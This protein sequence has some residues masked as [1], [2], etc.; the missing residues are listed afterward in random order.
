MTSAAFLGSV[1][2]D[3]MPPDQDVK[4]RLRDLIGIFNRAAPRAPGSGVSFLVPFVMPESDVAVKAV[5]GPGGDP[6]PVVT[7]ML[8]GEA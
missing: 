3:P 7:I 8:L 2:L 1:A 6:E 5:C 4:G